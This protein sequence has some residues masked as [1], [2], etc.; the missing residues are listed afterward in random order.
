MT[1]LERKNQLIEEILTIDNENLIIN[2]EEFLLSQARIE[3]FDFDSEWE[4]ALTVEEFRTEMHKT[5]AS[6]PWQKQ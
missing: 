3:K 5:I 2:I 4:K 1:L 6:F